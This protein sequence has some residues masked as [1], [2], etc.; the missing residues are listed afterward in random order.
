MAGCFAHRHH[1][2][3]K[4]PN[5]EKR[6]PAVPRRFAA[7]IFEHNGK[8]LVRQRPAGVVN[9]HLWEFPNIELPAPDA[10]LQKAAH[11]VLGF[12]PGPL[13]RL[14]QIRHSITRYRICLDAFTISSNH[15]KPGRAA[16][17][18][19]GPAALVKLPFPSAHRKILELL[20]EAG[21]TATK[22]TNHTK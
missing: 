2:V 7:F 1:Q 12:R 10:D 16:G 21:W 6:P 8:F 4:L 13:A 17:E 9:A 18:W 22:H 3:S 19:F 14:C 5:L 11:D 15:I 20:R